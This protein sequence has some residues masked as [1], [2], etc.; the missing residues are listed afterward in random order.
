M[1][2]MPILSLT[3]LPGSVNTSFAESSLRKIPYHGGES[4]DTTIRDDMSGS[5]VFSNPQQRMVAVNSR[6]MKNVFAVATREFFR[7]N[8]EFLTEFHANQKDGREGDFAFDIATCHAS[9]TQGKFFL[10][11][12]ILPET[13]GTEDYF[14]CLTATVSKMGKD[15]VRSFFCWIPSKPA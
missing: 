8:R 2:G 15:L 12:V 4:R 7:Q 10:E 1:K 11:G 13:N 6:E 9:V 3:F 14:V 5:V